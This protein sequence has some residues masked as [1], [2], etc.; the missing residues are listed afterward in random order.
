MTGAQRQPW[1]PPALLLRLADRAGES[2]GFELTP[3]S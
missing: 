1:S 2:F 3:V